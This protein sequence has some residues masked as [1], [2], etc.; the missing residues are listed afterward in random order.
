MWVV[1]PVA[2]VITRNATQRNGSQCNVGSEFKKKNEWETSCFVLLTDLI[3]GG[4]NI[5]FITLGS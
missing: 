4:F 5:A 3:S 2:A 1:N